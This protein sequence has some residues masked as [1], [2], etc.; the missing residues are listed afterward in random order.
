MGEIQLK[1]MLQDMGYPLFGIFNPEPD[2]GVFSYCR[3]YDAK[4]NS[5]AFGWRIIGGI[6]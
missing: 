2:Y 6:K 1:W 3:F 4:T 5:M